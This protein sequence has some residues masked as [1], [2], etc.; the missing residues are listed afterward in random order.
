MISKQIKIIAQNIRICRKAQGMTIPDLA[1]KPGISVSTLSAIEN[2]RAQN[3]SIR[4]LDDIATALK[5]SFTAIISPLNIQDNYSIPLKEFDEDDC[6]FVLEKK[7]IEKTYYPPNMRNHKISS[8]LELALILP[9]LDLNDL[10]DIYYRILGCAVNYEDYISELFDRCWNR[11]PDSPEKRY[12]QTELDTICAIRNGNSTAS[13]Q[14]A[15]NN[16]FDEYRKTLQNK[17]AN[18]NM[19][20][21]LI[22]NNVLFN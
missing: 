19:L 2:E 10:Y 21:R 8:M 3:I 15:D 20:R 14:N 13:I 5:T 1:E 11:V 9:L 16:G 7:A 22:N 18:I 6:F 17:Q 12:I 4:T